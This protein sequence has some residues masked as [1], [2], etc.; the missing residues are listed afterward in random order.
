MKDAKVTDKVIIVG[1]GIVGICSAIALR[2]SG[3]KVLM[4]DPNDPGQGAS[5]GNAGIISPWSIIPQFSPDLWKQVPAIILQKD[6]PLSVMASHWPA[7]LS[8]GMRFLANGRLA[9]YLSTVEKMEVLTQDCP[10]LYRSFLA[11]TGHEH[12]VTDSYYVHAFR[13]PARAKIDS[14]EYLLRAEAGAEIRQIHGGELQEMEPH[15]S[16]DFQT[17]ILIGGQ[18]RAVSPGKIG[19]V[20]TDKA[21]HM[22]VD[23]QREEVHSLRP[24]EDGC[25]I[26]ETNRSAHHGAKILI[27]AGV[28]S[29][30]LLEPLG[31]KFPLQA[32][33]G[34]NVEYGNS[35]IV[36]NNS[37]MDME[38]KTVASSM[39]HAL[40]V[41]GT[42]EFG[43]IGAPPNRKRQEAIERISKRMFPGLDEMKPKHWMGH[44]PSLP[45]GL[46]IIGELHRHKGLFG[47]FGH[48][49]YGLMMAPRTGRLIAGIIGSAPTNTDLSSFSSERFA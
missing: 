23:V 40:R 1:A 39:E 12:L 36:V 27:S 30:K 41:A 6:G 48:S 34:Y 43:P 44:R 42:A 13:D 2:E 49:H 9:N 4:L 3:F 5:A 46:P 20:L 33:R 15:L 14:S 35:G 18:A 22:G 16:L 31:Y 26:V 45:D 28:W 21:R 11:G 8:W 47:A 25:W 29:R 24:T 37:V 7:F 38:Y 19:E 32:E 10:A 17:A